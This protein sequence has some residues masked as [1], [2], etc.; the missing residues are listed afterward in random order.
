MP[1]MFVPDGAKVIFSF[2]VNENEKDSIP[3]QKFN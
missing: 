3:L 2:C 1:E